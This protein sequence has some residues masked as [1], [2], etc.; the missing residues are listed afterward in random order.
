MF[1]RWEFDA[2]IKGVLDNDFRPIPGLERRPG[3]PSLEPFRERFFP[4]KK[5]E[6]DGEKWLRE[7]GSEVASRPF[8]AYISPDLKQLLI[9]FTL[10]F[11]ADKQKFEEIRQFF[12]YHQ[13][14]GF[15]MTH[16]SLRGSTD[17]FTDTGKWFFPDTWRHA[18]RITSQ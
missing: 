3:M 2:Q 18:L 15:S 7:Y 16:C 11:Q 9:G 12:Y 1:D 8:F 14:N 4:K 5:K 13:T 10:K 6:Q 17:T